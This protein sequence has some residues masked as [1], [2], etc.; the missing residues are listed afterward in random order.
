VKSKILLSLLAAIAP[1]LAATP[2]NCGCD[3]CKGKEVCCCQTETAATAA[4]VVKRHPLRGVITAVYAE[5]SA[6]M[7]KHEAIPGVM[8]A[9]TMLFKVDAATLKFAQKGQAI[10][11]MMSRQG[12]DWWLHDVKTVAVPAK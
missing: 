12:D 1:L 3:C 4:E 10:T 7:V 2:R 5:R 11:G 9:M 8:R 6:I